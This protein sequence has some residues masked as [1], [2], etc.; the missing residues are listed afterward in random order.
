M[1]SARV[2]D[3]PA[4]ERV[5]LFGAPPTT[6]RD[7][8]AQIDAKPFCATQLS[9]WFY[10][11]GV[12]DF[13]AMTNLSAVVRASLD[14]SAQ[15][16][17]PQFA[18][19]EL[20][21]D[22]TCKWE[23]LLH[24]GARV[25]SVYIPEAR[26]GTL[27]ISSQLGC[28]LDCSFCATGKQGFQRNLSAAE[29][30]GQLWRAKQELDDFGTVPPAVTNVVFMGMGEPLLNFEQVATAVRI[31]LDDTGFALARRRVTISTAGVAP[32][33]ERIPTEAA[34]AALA[35]SLHAPEDDLRN[36]LV[37]LNKKYPIADVLEAVQCY[38]SQLPPAQRT[39]T[40]QYTL[41]DGVN[42]DPALAHSLARLLR[43][44]PC[45]IN[46]IP[47]NPFGVS[48][49]RRP[50]NKKIRTFQQLLKDAGYVATVRST[51]GNDI[52]AACGRLVGRVR[53]RSA[54]T[55]SAPSSR[56]IVSAGC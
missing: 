20:S 53:D 48:E 6:V 52:A 8:F 16:S 3:A 11:K 45:K 37:P 31:M 9:Q 13:N 25:E 29:I 34:G 46:L 1:S 17:L 7:F 5:N 42:D 50:S 43:D 2:A 23:V 14:S 19:P 51:R 21:A 10:R 44:I 55:R 22:G 56:L 18:H 47:F 15:A 39:V 4:T 27:C 26:R 12:L 38:L 30:V 24:D 36:V 49:Y 33:M 28:V 41:I 54:R 40:F 32:V 35:V